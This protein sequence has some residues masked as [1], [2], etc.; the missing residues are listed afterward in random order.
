MK[1]VLFGKI[2]NFYKANLHTH[3]TISD[4]EM[5]P[6]EAKEEYK[7]RGY[8][9]LAY[10][11]H[12]VLVPHN[13]LTDE[14]F[15]AITSYEVAVDE[16]VA[17]APFPF[18]YTCHLNFFAKDKNK[19][20]S[21]CF[22]QDHIWLGKSYE[23]VSEEQK[24]VAYPAK[25]TVDCLN[26]MIKKANED[27]FL[28]TLNHPAWSMQTYQDYAPLKGLWGVEVYNGTCDYAGFSE[29]ET[30][31]VDLLNLGNNIVPIAADDTHWRRAAYLGWTIIE[32]EE[33]SYEKVFEAMEKGSLYS[34]NGPSIY[35][36]S[37]DGTKLFVRCSKAKE[38]RLNT[39]LRWTKVVHG[40]ELTE[41]EIDL[42]D[43]YNLKKQYPA[44]V[45]PYIRIT[46]EDEKGDRAWSR[47]YS[48]EEFF[49]E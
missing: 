4:G 38:V 22:N 32:A 47:G 8:S 17:G 49:S 13:D 24:K 35:E 21:P 15:L 31:F 43:Y 19:S 2:G 11:D 10:T 16:R 3:T 29:T 14:G 39:E 45:K 7:K 41:A 26:D 34:S 9:I 25:Y 12:E 18:I 48:L 36:I 28:V 33:L 5:S 27:G 1:K 44:R 42:T 30:P 37:I 6:E 23:Y 40:E 46:V 20:V